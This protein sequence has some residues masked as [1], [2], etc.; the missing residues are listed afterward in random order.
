MPCLPSSPF[1][2]A[3]HSAPMSSFKQLKEEREARQAGPASVSRPRAANELA[4]PQSALQAGTSATL[5]LRPTQERLEGNG[6]LQVRMTKDRGRG[7]FWCPSDARRAGRGE[8]FPL[9][10]RSRCSHHHHPSQAP[11]CSELSQRSWWPHQ[12]SWRACATAAFLPRR[13][14]PLFN[15]AQAAR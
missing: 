9:S 13:R 7:L 3:L 1:A 8:C 4:P 14:Q 12:T 2:L 15:A 10:P 5:P 11:R 6:D